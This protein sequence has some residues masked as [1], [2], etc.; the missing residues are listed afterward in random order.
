MSVPFRIRP[1][2]KNKTWE[3]NNDPVTLDAMYVRLL[4]DGGDRLLSD[5]VKWLAVT[6]KSFDQGRRGFND[7]LTYLGR[8]IVELQASLALVVAPESPSSYH[9]AD[10][11]GRVPFTHPQLAG[12]ANVSENYKASLLSKNRLSQLA[13]HYGIPEVLRWKPRKVCTHPP[14]R[15]CCVC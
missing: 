8:R 7:R 9:E 10:A 1:K 6:H 15:L 2:L 3:C 11:H 5:E 14:P 12:L 4:G 13:D